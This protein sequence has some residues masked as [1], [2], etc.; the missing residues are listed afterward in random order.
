MAVQH[1]GSLEHSRTTAAAVLKLYDERPVRL[2]AVRLVAHGSLRQIETAI[3]LLKEP[4]A[5]ALSW[6]VDSSQN[7][8][9]PVL[10]SADIGVELVALAGLR[11]SGKALQDVSPL[12]VDEL[13]DSEKWLDRV[14]LPAEARGVLRRLQAPGS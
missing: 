3:H 2:A 6:L 12:H 9:E 11:R 7:D 13:I 10:P 8:V 5:A 4:L 1:S 14:P